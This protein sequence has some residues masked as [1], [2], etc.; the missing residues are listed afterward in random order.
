VDR[1]PKPLAGA[2]PPDVGRQDDELV[3]AVA[4]VPRVERLNSEAEDVAP[5]L[6]ERVVLPEA[7]MFW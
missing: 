7:A 1:E 2:I 3:D 4:Q 5:P 6:Q